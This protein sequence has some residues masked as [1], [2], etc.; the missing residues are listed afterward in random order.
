VASYGAEDW[1]VFQYF[2]LIRSDVQDS[3]YSTDR[4]DTGLGGLLGLEG[5]WLAMQYFQYQEIPSVGLDSRWSSITGGGLRLVHEPTM[6]LNLL[7]GLA[8]QRETDS[9]GD[10]SA[11]LRELPVVLDWQLG[12]PKLDL[13][14]HVIAIHYEGLTESD[15]RRTDLRLR[16]EHEIAENLTLGLQFLF[17]HDNEPL[18]PAESNTDRSLIL[19]VGYQF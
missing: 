14:L 12:M 19:S 8:L 15:R 18:D 1:K 16:L 9:S 6:D 4:L 11:T 3:G 5:R 10:R 7:T 2:T 17:N 13:E